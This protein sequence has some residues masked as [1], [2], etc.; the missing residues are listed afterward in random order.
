MNIY[1]AGMG[2]KHAR[3]ANLP[4]EVS[5]DTFHASLASFGKV[6]NVHNEMWPKAYRYPVSNG[7]RQVT[8]YL[9]RHLPSH[10]TIAGHRVFLSYESQPATCYGC[11]EVGH[12]YQA[13]NLLNTELPFA[14]H[15]TSRQTILV[16]DFNCALNPAYTTG[17]FLPSRALSEIVRNLALIDTWLQDPLRPTFTHHSPTGATRLDRFYVSAN[18]V[19]RKS[20]V[21][22]IP[23]AFTDHHAVAL[24]LTIQ[25]PI[26]RRRLRRWRMDPI[27]MH[28]DALRRKIRDKL[29]Q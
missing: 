17:S 29:M 5:N 6:L 10:L 2:T 9:T 14:F 7:L 16:R 12:L 3:V 8:M 27:V 22:I 13:K 28:D 4:P 24:R 26:V 11:G 15:T 18:R 20:S 23:A 21:E 1:L 25:G 19:R